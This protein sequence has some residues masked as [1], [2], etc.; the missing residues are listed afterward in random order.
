MLIQAKGRT[1]SCAICSIMSMSKPCSGSDRSVPGAHTG[2]IAAELP[3]TSIAV[4][5]QGFK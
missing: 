2:G 5:A 4:P 1:R 3:G